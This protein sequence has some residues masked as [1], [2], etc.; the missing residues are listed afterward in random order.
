MEGTVQ[1]RGASEMK[2][3]EFIGSRGEPVVVLSQALSA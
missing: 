2:V 1:R 3:E